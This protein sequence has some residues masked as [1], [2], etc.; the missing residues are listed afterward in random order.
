MTINCHPRLN[1]LLL[2]LA[3]LLATASARA[4][5]TTVA[6]WHLGEND[7]NAADGVTATN[8]VEVV[9]GDTLT[10]S[11]AATYTANVAVSATAATGSSLAVQL[12]NA[13]Y[14]TAAV[15]PNLTNNFG[16]ECWVNPG[17][18]TGGKV[19][20]YNGNTSSSG[21]GIYQ[22]GNTF[23]GL[24]GGV[25]YFGGGTTTAG[26]WTHVAIVCTDG[27]F[28]F[29]VNG[30]PAVALG[31]SAPNN[32]AGNFLLGA[33]NVH[34]ENFN[35]ALDEVRVF[36]FAPGAFSTNDLLLN[37]SPV[38][39]STNDSGPGSLRQAIN[40]ASS[41]STITFATNLSGQTITLT[42]GALNLN[43]SLTID[44]SAL[45]GGISINGNTNDY[46]FGIASGATVFLNSLIITNGF[47]GEAYAGGGILN[48]G[49]LTMNQCTLAGNAGR[50]SG[51]IG[52]YAGKLTLN[53]C[54][55]AGNSGVNGGGIGNF[56]NASLCTL[57]E[58]TLAGN[59]A[60]NGGAIFNDASGVLA[61]NQSTLADNN[62]SVKGG[63]I[64]NTN[65]S[66]DAVS[67]SGS[68]I[69]ANT[70]PSGADIYNAGTAAIYPFSSKGSP[71]SVNVIGTSLVQTTAG[72]ALGGT[73][74]G[75]T[76]SPQF[77]RAAPLLAPLGN[78][79]GPTQTM[80]P[81]LGSPA[82]NA[83]NPSDGKSNGG[84]NS[85]LTDQRGFPRN[86]GRGFDLGAVQLQ[87]LSLVVT[88]SADSGAGS[89]RQILN[90]VDVSSTITFD[91]GLSGQT[92]QL[93]SGELL[94]T[95]S[96]VIDAS[97]LPD[98]LQINGNLSDRIF[99]VDSFAPVTLTALTLTSG[100]ANDGYGG[101]GILN[102]SMLTL[103]RCTLSGNGASGNV[104]GGLDNEGTNTLNECTLAGNSAG[105][106]GGLFNYGTLTLNA[107]TVSG[108]GATS[109]YGGGGVYNNGSLTLIGS[110]VGAN[111]ATIG[112]DIF[113]EGTLTYAGA[114]L[115]KFVI[116]LGSAGSVTGPAP[117]NAAPLLAPLGN[118]GGP[119]PTLPPLPGSPAIDAAGSSLFSTDQRGLPRVLGLG[120]DLGA[121]EGVYNSAGP[122]RLVGLTETSGSPG[123]FGFYF[124][125][126]SDM[127]F[128]VLT[129]TNLG[130][131]LNQ[132]QAIGTVT[133]A[134][135][136][137]GVYP[138]TDPQA[139]NGPQG[140][141]RVSW[142]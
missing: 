140:F 118:Y 75:P 115:A 34:G 102:E 84:G 20:V 47:A 111:R 7:P 61:V 31:Y 108:N 35:G 14:G 110:I 26:V 131:P 91:P 37:Q 107:C 38:V 10:F 97:A 48:V 15:I 62:A 44:A 52:N 130:L 80:P 78:Y 19:V 30:V 51:A 45:A 137:S 59:A 81:L 21:W 13:A 1:F 43:Q 122:G 119:T 95:D 135:P 60:T 96:L 125:N 141:Y 71:G 86:V 85:F 82:I 136:G 32:P 64:Y 33:N 56:G 105:I 50:T 63:G 139:T 46:V 42:S 73:A 58:C 120:P 116:N 79:G 27:V 106:G 126:S 76:Y 41:G 133:E 117:I 114:N 65:K 67:L 54:V 142:P 112:G 83:I 57:N 129:S 36:T 88:S 69:A 121:V 98:G 124:T 9:G 68:I 134:V 132:W 93:T 92:I 89:L 22:F 12:T 2:L 6:Y 109:G 4:T 8:S 72:G 39:T 29:Y 127:S 17:D 49:T 99:E 123:G 23:S 90:Q 18:T 74:N 128:T 66:V 101:G 24:L 77:I 5:V 55:V 3:S 87:T 16:L 138:F 40:Y 100:S 94:L 104:G 11:G 103:N 53:Q 28:T 25:E 70:A 113:T